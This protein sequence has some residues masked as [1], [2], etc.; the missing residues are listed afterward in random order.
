VAQL[1]PAFLDYALSRNLSDGVLLAGCAGGDCLYRQGAEWTSQ[2]IQRRRD[3][4]LRQRVDSIRIAMT[5]ESPWSDYRDPSRLL[6]AFSQ[7]LSGGSKDPARGGP[8]PLF[9]RRI[10]QA[11]ALVAS[12]GLLALSTGWFSNS[13]RYRLLESNQAM[14]AL[15]FSHAGQRLH[16]CRTLSQDD[17]N[18]L[19]PNMRT[20]VDCPRGRHPV[21]VEFYVDGEL[22]YRD[23]L[24]PSGLWDDGES[25]VYK[26]LKLSAGNRHLLIGMRDSG[27]TEGFDY[28]QEETLTLS[29]QQNLLVEYDEL[30]KS[31]L[32]R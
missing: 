3:P 30:S 23:V 16:E 26:R 29:E 31:F 6:E 4:Y 9:H 15:S 8:G 27:R 14:I 17:L 32:F 18:R 19:P 12:Y 22:R 5:W 24:S 11:V 1:P 7:S 20:P 13:P 10:L 25:N 21:E 2:R 28:Q